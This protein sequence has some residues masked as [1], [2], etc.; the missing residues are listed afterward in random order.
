MYLILLI[1]CYLSL[2]SFAVLKTFWPK[3][4]WGG[5]SLLLSSLLFWE[6]G[7][8]TEAETSGKHH[9]LPSSHSAMFHTQPR[10]GVAHGGLSPPTSTSNRE[11]ALQATLME[12]VPPTSLFIQPRLA[13]TIV[14][15]LRQWARLAA[16]ACSWLSFLGTGIIDLDD[17]TQLPFYQGG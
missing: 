10:H 1:Y 15:F 5:K 7:P 13:I 16:G 12:A 3:A 2:V 4:I 6:A 9:S 11:N 17:H 14:T 8:E